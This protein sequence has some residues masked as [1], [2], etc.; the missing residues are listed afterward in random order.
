MLLD[1]PDLKKKK[2][3]GADGKGRNRK[4][5]ALLSCVKRE[6]NQTNQKKK[7]NGNGCQLEHERERSDKSEWRKEEASQSE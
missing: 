3:N 5:W 1:G 6:R 4:E 7:K 2:M